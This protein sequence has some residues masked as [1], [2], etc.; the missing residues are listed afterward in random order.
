MTVCSCNVLSHREI[1]DSLGAGDRLRTL[2]DCVRIAGKAIA[3]PK[4][5]CCAS[6]QDFLAWRAMSDNCY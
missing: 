2:N 5:D 6:A 4:S 1:R 3:R